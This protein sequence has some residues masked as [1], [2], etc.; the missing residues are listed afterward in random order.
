M[1]TKRQFWFRHIKAWQQGQLSQ[2]EYARQHGLSVKSFSYYRRCF[3]QEHQQSQQEIPVS[4]LP[5]SVIPEK[6][7]EPP[8]QATPGITLTSPGGFRIEL[9]SGFDPQTL[10]AILQLLRL[11]DR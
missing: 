10:Q 7:I 6:Q 11:H 4:L 1:S 9:A 3:A 2:A 5:V 8:V